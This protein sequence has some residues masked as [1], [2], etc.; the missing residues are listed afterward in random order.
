VVNLRG[1]G[2]FDSTPVTITYDSD[3]G[4]YQVGGSSLSRAQLE[5]EVDAGDLRGL[6]TA[7]LPLNFGTGTHPQPVIAPPAGS[8]STGNPDLDFSDPLP[9]IGTGVRVDAIVFVDG[10][11]VGGSVSCTA[12][13][14]LCI[15]GGMSIDFASGLSNGMH[16]VQLQ[17]PK[18]PLSNEVPVCQGPAGGC[19]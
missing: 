10:L 1:D 18:G 16:L 14:D 4:L 17:N 7:F 15:D 3:A 6:L 19:L 8:G 5:S 2:V 13:G 11:P 12:I 9:V